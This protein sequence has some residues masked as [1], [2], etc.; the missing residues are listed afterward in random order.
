MKRCT[1]FYTESTQTDPKIE[2]NPTRGS[3]AKHLFKNK[4]VNT[5]H[6]SICRLVSLLPLTLPDTVC[7]LFN[8]NK[9]RV[10]L[11]KKRQMKK[12]KIIIMHNC[13]PVR[14]ARVP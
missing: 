9:A 12:V 7:N 14:R 10:Q 5:L 2:D 3:K 4:P 8:Q 1:L 13:Q 11:M 6:F